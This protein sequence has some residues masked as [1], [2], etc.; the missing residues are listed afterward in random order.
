MS[1]VSLISTKAPWLP[2]LMTVLSPLCMLHSFGSWSRS[3]RMK[4][5]FIIIS[6][7]AGFTPYCLWF[8]LTVR[9]W[10]LL[11]I[12]RGWLS[13]KILK[14]GSLGSVTSYE[15]KI[16]F[17]LMLVIYVCLL[18][19][20]IKFNYFYMY[21]SSLLQQIN[22]I[23]GFM[24]LSLLYPWPLPCNFIVASHSGS[25]FDHVTCFGQ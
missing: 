25:G 11:L 16:I 24:L 9:W 17:H 7:S 22:C 4:G 2:E 19:I 23:H 18:C 5:E 21:L 12:H 20:Y 6:S 3:H 13:Q 15:I 1:Q 10:C 14:E 8:S